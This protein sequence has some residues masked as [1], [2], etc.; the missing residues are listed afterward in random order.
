MPDIKISSN[1]VIVYVLRR[2]DKGVEVLFLKRNKK[3][4]L[5]NFWLHV[6]GKIEDGE[7]AWQAALRELKEETGLVP[8]DF[9]TS[10]Y[11]E[12]FYS[13]S[14]DR[15]VILPMFVAFVDKKAQ[16]LLNE[17]HSEYKWFSLDEARKAVPFNNQKECLRVVEQNFILAAPPEFLRIKA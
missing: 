6:A 3:D 13:A 16:I 11:C 9:Y 5:D 7:T 14:N 2:T 8:Q 4:G 17:E 1:A 10:N 12:Q 15:L